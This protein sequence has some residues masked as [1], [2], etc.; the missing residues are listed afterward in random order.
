MNK[1]LA[2]G[3]CLLAL[4]LVTAGCLEAKQDFVVHGDGS[5]IIELE[6]KLG[7]EISGMASSEFEGKTQEQLDAIAAAQMGEQFEGVYWETMT[8]KLVDGHLVLKGTGVFSDISKVKMISEEMDMEAAMEEGAEPK[9]VKKEQLVFTFE[10]T[11]AGG[12]LTMKM[13]SGQAGAAMGGGGAPEGMEGNE[14]M[15]KEMA[16]MMEEAMKPMLEQMK[17][18]KFR[19]SAKVP[20]EVTK[21]GLKDL[22]EGRHGIEI[23]VDMIQKQA[24]AGKGGMDGTIEWKGKTAAPTGFADRVAKAKKAWEAG[25]KARNELKAKLEGEKAEGGEMDLEELEKKLKEA[26]GGAEKK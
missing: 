18:F 23:D 26:E 19:I 2:F 11:D 7:K 15:A 12:K 10:Q 4:S 17:G 8:Q 3:A 16:K 6:F 25:A 13:D 20:G 21:S 14:E 5:G 9:M 24:L 1:H 22:G